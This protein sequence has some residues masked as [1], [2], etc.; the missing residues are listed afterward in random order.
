MAFAQGSRSGLSYI[1]EVTFGTTPA[2]NFTALPFNTHSLNVT[3]ERV[4]GNDIQSDRIVRNDRHGNAQ[5]GGEIVV[6]LRRGDYDDL[7]QS[8]FFSTFSTDVIEV[9][10]T[11]R[12]LSIED[13]ANDIGQYRLFTG[14]ACSSMAI[15]IAPNQMVTA[16]FNMVGKGGTVS[17]T[18]KTV[19]AAS[20]N[21]PMDAYSGSIS[22]DDNGQ[23]GV[24]DEIAIVTA[25]DF[26]LDNSM[27]PTFVVG[28]NETPQLEYGLGRVEGTMSAYFEDASLLNRFLNETE[29][30]LEVVIDDP[31][32]A[33]TYTFFMPRVKLNGAEIPVSDPQS[34]IIN[35]P[36]VALYDTTEGTNLRLTRTT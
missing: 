11:P 23:L 22:I 10:T 5:A 31:S 7:I 12:F 32:A 34:R 28:S 36:F 13:A 2:G 21:P 30:A 18:G 27:Q 1:S 8:A 4:E 20:T 15:S 25:I 26:T 3:K 9:G 6:D 24:G 16:T 29:S 33:S 35:I 17:G 14:M 19:D